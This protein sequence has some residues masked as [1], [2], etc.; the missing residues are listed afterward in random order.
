MLDG[1]V[2]TGGSSV[3]HLRIDIPDEKDADRVYD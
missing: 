1:K 3:E 2:G